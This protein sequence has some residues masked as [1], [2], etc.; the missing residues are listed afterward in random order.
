MVPRNQPRD[1]IEKAVVEG[2]R[3]TTNWADG[4]SRWITRG[5]GVRSGRMR[6]TS[7]GGC[8]AESP[9][10][11]GGEDAGPE[12]TIRVSQSAS[13]N[14]SAGAPRTPRHWPFSGSAPRTENDEHAIRHG[15]H[16]GKPS[17]P[18]GPNLRTDVVDH[19]HAEPPDRR[20]KAEIESEKSIDEGVDVSRAD[21][22]SRRRAV[23]SLGSL[24][25]HWS[26]RS[27]ELAVVVDEATTRGS[28]PGPPKT[29]NLE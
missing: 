17:R 25:I 22:T 18:R 1:W 21:A 7:P 29:G 9:R 27:G 11:R 16:R 14:R 3:A 24:G 8:L 4:M 13:F 23:R 26:I 20:R 10:W 28:E 2:A 15:A 19:R 5:C 6:E 12:G